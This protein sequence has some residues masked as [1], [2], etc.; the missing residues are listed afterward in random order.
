MLNTKPFRDALDGWEN[1]KPK[2]RSGQLRTAYDYLRNTEP[3]TLALLSDPGVAL[4][5]DSLVAMTT[6]RSLGCKP[7]WVLQEEGPLALMCAPAFPDYV[8]RLVYP[9]TIA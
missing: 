5:R 6:A 1:T 2:P 7:S 8:W 3:E 9:E 4:Q